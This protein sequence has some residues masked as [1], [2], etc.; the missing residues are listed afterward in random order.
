MLRKLAIGLSVILVAATSNVAMAGPKGGGKSGG[1]VPSNEP[2]LIDRMAGAT[3]AGLEGDVRAAKA[4]AHGNVGRAVDDA[5]FGAKL[6]VLI[7]TGR[8]GGGFG[9]KF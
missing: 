2:G 1:F 9:G 7:L 8:G 3:K 4:L 6:G 5:V